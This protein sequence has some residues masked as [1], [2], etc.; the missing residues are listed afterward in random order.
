MISHF[1]IPSLWAVP[2]H[3]STSPLEGKETT[4]FSL[5]C[6]GHRHGNY[7]ISTCLTLVPGL[8]WLKAKGKHGWGWRA[9]QMTSRSWLQGGVP[10]F[11]LVGSSKGT[12]TRGLRGKGMV[13]G[14]REA[15]HRGRWCWVGVGASRALRQET[16]EGGRRQMG[17]WLEQWPLLFPLL[18][19]AVLEPDLRRRENSHNQS[20]SLK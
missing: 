9:G 4:Q 19:S 17:Q 6:E 7:L 3:I 14:V 1:N 15:G 11:R 18:S 8:W 13:V 12:T 10:V 2:H 16:R 20:L 5:F